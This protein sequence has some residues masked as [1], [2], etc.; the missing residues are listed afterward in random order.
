M[1]VARR[2]A[3]AVAMRL[4]KKLPPELREDPDAREIRDLLHADSVSLDIVQLIYRAQRYENHAKDYEFSRLTMQEHWASGRADVLQTLKDPRWTQR[5]PAEPYGVRV[6]DLAS[7]DRTAV[8][9]PLGVL[10]HEPA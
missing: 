7:P 9:T 1:D 10:E 6:F 2:R 4:M 8:I 5:G 3:A